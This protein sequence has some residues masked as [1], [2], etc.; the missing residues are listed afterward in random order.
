MDVE[1]VQT[2]TEAG[3]L[4]VVVEHGRREGGSSSI[5]SV[6]VPLT[7]L[8]G[9]TRAQKRAVV[10]AALRAVIAPLPPAAGDADV[11]AGLRLTL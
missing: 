7:D 11:A 10:A 1:I 3:A 8:A 6:A 5:T 4:H 9:K 2:F